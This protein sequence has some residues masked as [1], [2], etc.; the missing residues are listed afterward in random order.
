[1]VIS[2]RSFIACL[3]ALLGPRAADAQR[4]GH[5]P[6]IGI[7]CPHRLSG[8]RG[9]PRDVFEHALGGLGWTPGSNVELEYRD[10]EKNDDALAEGAAGLIRLNVDVIV[11]C[12]GRAT[13]GAQQSTNAIPI[14][15]SATSD[16]NRSDFFFDMLL[17]GRRDN[18][19][20][21]VL[22]TT[23]AGPRALELL[24]EAGTGF[25]RIAILW[26]I[27]TPSHSAKLKTV[28]D[29]AR[30]L[31]IQVRPVGVRSLSDL[32]SAFAT[33]QREDVKALLVLGSPYFFA[34][35]GRIVELATRYRLPSMFDSRDATEA[36][37]LMS[38]SANHAA[39]YRRAA[40][41]VDKLLRGARPADLAIEQLSQF[42]LVINLKTAKALGLTIPPSV[43][44][45]A[46]QLIK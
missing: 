22:L 42:E 13:R 7:L 17:N 46:D 32:P 44:Q 1:M 26:D 6:R 37:G 43:L 28:E 16:P 3:G 2:R 18:V 12:G 8:A 10:A 5:V 11:T 35:R 19:T 33:M 38:Y 25:D 39:L 40:G 23:G 27:R 14:V 36:G 30:S 34:E 4:S 21:V 15:M 29:A 41:Y 9:M 31:R 20:G 24:S 45:R